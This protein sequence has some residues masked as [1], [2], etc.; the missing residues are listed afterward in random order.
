MPNEQHQKELSDL[1]ERTSKVLDR[2]PWPDDNAAQHVRSDV[3]TTQQ[4]ATE[5][6]LR[7]LRDALNNLLVQIDGYLHAAP[8]EG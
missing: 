8:R 4:V 1:A 2:L 6:N 7:R 5:Q 3:R